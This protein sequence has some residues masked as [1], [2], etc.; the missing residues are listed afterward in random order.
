M[1]AIEIKN[2]NKK[3][4]N[5]ELKDISLNVKKGSIMGLIGENGAGKTTI[6]KCILSISK[7]DGE[8]LVLGEKININTKENINAVLDDVFLSEYLNPYEIESILSGIYK[9][10]DSNYYFELLDKFKINIKKDIKDFSKGMKVKLKIATA[11][12]SKP[13]LLI[14]D[15]P[16][17]GLDPV[18]RDEILDILL[19]FVEDEENS[20][21]ISSHITNDLEKIA[22]YIT[23]VEDGRLIFSEDKYELL[24]NYAILRTSEEDFKNVDRSFVER[25]KINKYNTEALITNV[26][27]FKIKYPNLIVDKLDLDEM[28]VFYAKGNKYE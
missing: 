27:K 24:E 1:N 26:E 20:V 4:D 9:N 25:Y 5:F 17:A 8:I 2:L 7:Y 12:S 3:Y 19:E 13:K 11:L 10:W 23:F 6:L 22:D 18:V 14:L 15:E 16:T 28:M 21:L